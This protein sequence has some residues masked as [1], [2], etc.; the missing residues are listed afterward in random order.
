MALF[1]L[2]NDVTTTPEASPE[3][4]HSKVP[5]YERSLYTK[6]QE[7]YPNIKPMVIEKSCTEV[8]QKAMSIAKDLG[9]EIVSTSDLHFEAIA[10][11][12]FLRFKDDIVVETRILPIEQAA[13]IC[14]VHMR[15]RS[16]V[17]KSDLGANAARIADFFN[18]LRQ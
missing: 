8:F 4:K 7:L 9:W 6:Q 11:T 18:K 14:E 13:N 10:T 2:L 16:R 3:F 17:G 15:S 1:I 5:A 12:K